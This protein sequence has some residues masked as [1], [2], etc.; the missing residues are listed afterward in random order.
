M[1]RKLILAL[2]VAFLACAPAHAQTGSA[3]TP[4]ALVTETNALFPDQS[5]GGITPF[6]MRQTLLDVIASYTPLTGSGTIVGSLTI[7][8]IAGINPGLTINQTLTGS[9]GAF[10]WN[11]INIASDNVAGAFMVYQNVQAMFGGAAAAGT[12]VGMFANL[13]Q[14]AATSASNTSRF[15][16]GVQGQSQTNS[17]DGGTNT[18]AGAFGGYYGGDFIAKVQGTNIGT[19][20][21]SEFD[22]M[23]KSG[24]TARN[25][26]GI[27][28]SN[29]MAA[30]GAN[31]DAAIGIGAGSQ[32]ASNL[33]GGPW[34]AGVGFSNGILFLEL[35]QFDATQAI[36]PIA[37]TGT[38]L[39]T[40][41]ETM[42]NFPVT[43]GIDLRGF[44]ISGLAYATTGFTVNGNGQTDINR[45][46][47]PASVTALGTATGLRL[48][49]ADA[50]S[51]AMILDAFAGSPTYNGRRAGGT[52]ASKAGVGT[53]D[54][55]AQLVGL[56]FTSAAAYSGQMG[57][58]RITAAETYTA[59]AQGT[60]LDFVA[61]PNTTI[62]SVVAMTLQA[63]GGLSVGTTTD[64]GIGA[65]LANT[66]IKSQGATAGIGYATGAGG[67]ITQATNKATAVTLN[68]V[69]GAITMNNAALAAGTI[70]SFT[71]TDSAIAATDVFVLNHISG[72]TIGSYTLNAQ[73]A[74]GTATINIRNNT[75]GSLSEA[76][77]IEFA[78]LK[79]VTS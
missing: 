12:R 5:A 32:Q 19:V 43:N 9:T 2:S 61:T 47:T 57:A 38:V 27:F 52:A 40:H 22:V 41:L 13:I 26:M 3:K 11:N 78:V 46:T 42:S 23:S 68:T 21:G 70:V 50:A 62:L 36:S 20:I 64:P 18:G 35:S 77:V 63:S 44:S 54:V 17:A 31:V 25:V 66:S 51:T 75:A 69:T 58:L 71:L 1:L 15:Y 67:T 73:A 49:G 24:A 6:D 30:A 76:I 56:G 79:G 4:A 37:S 59:S 53:G 14:T 45:S 10:Y 55:L 60:R 72:G 74:A 16:V 29:F 28:V 65:F 48:A 39:G 34:G 8:P 7:N 33:G